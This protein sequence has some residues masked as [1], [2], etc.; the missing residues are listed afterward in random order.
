MLSVLV[1]GKTFFLD[2]TRCIRNA[3]QHL[4]GGNEKGK[5]GTLSL[6]GWKQG[7]SVW[8][9]AKDAAL[10]LNRALQKANLFW[11]CI[12]FTAFWRNPIKCF[13]SSCQASIF[14]KSCPLQLLLASNQQCMQV[15]HTHTPTRTCPIFESMD[16]GRLSM[17]ARTWKRLSMDWSMYYVLSPV[18]CPEI[19]SLRYIK[20]IVQYVW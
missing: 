20:L 13:F 15:D 4:E 19:I 11:E 17:V 3:L 12:A 10:A 14:F 2:L 5:K 16:R 18:M 1:S 9:L 7:T 8:M 6:L